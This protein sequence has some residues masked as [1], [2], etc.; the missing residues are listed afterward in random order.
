VSSQ[1]SIDLEM[2]S[3]YNGIHLEHE[4]CKLFL[5][6]TSRELTDPTTTLLLL[7]IMKVK[8]TGKPSSKGNTKLQVDTSTKLDPSYYEIV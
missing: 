1:L 3:I 6:Q 8:T 5:K 2:E 4:S 7:L